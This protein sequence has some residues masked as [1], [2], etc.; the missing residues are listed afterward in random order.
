M[1]VILMPK[2]KKEKKKK[3]TN[4]LNKS[5]TLKHDCS[6][7]KSC[8]P[9]EKI[10]IDGY[11]ITNKELIVL[12][13]LINSS[14]I[15]P[16][17]SHEKLAALMFLFNNITLSILEDKILFENAF[18]SKELNQILENLSKKGFLSIDRRITTKQIIDIIMKTTK[19]NLIQAFISIDLFNMYKKDRIWFEINTSKRKVDKIQADREKIIEEMMDL[20]KIDFMFSPLEKKNALKKKF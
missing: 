3:I 8:E 6:K 4:K 9:L 18:E 7:P 1:I 11:E 20:M 13:M 12:G 17:M 10:I 5:I 14:D 15:K 19:K 2:A 16:K